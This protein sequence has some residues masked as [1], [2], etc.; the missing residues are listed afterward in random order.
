MYRLS[1]KQRSDLSNETLPSD[2]QKYQ[3]DQYSPEVKCF[4]FHIFLFENYRTKKKH[5]QYIGSAYQTDDG[6]QRIRKRNAV[7]IQIISNQ[8]KQTNKW[9]RPAPLKWCAVFSFG[10]PK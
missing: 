5:N 9:N 6:D 8:Q 1:G 4:S 7:E 2:H 3:T 10:I